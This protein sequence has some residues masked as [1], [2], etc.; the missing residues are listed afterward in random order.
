M[1][2]EL[3]TFIWCDIHQAKEEDVPGQPWA[4]L[5]D[6]N[7][8]REHAP[9]TVDLCDDCAADLGLIALRELIAEH[10]IDGQGKRTKRKAAPAPAAPA[11]GEGI[12][13][14]D[15]GAVYPDRNT[16]GAHARRQ[17]DKAIAEL[18][19][20]PTPHVCEECGR[21]FG[22]PQALAVHRTRSHPS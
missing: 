10:G 7:P 9:R 20:E 2:T 3:R 17:H 1:A 5:A 22:V 16:L 12:A 13:C 18:L 19:G 15:C 6:Q 8:T 21:A 4:L 14:P 11:A